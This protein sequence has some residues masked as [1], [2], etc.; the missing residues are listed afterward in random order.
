MPHLSVQTRAIVSRGPLNEDAWEIRDVALAPLGETE[1]MVR[2]SSV[3]LCHTDLSVGNTP[4]GPESPY[5]AVFGH[6]GK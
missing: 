4:A 5:P 1:L 2:I 6:E 3:G